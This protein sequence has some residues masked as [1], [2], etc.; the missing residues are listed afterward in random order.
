MP[1][2]IRVDSI[3]NFQHSVAEGDDLIVNDLVPDPG[4]LSDAEIDALERTALAEP[5]IVGGLLSK[6]AHVSSV[7]VRLEMPGDSRETTAVNKEVMDYARALRDDFEARYPNL[8]IHLMGQVVVNHAFNEIAEADAATLVPVM[9]VA[10][11]A[12]VGLFLRSLWS[13]VAMSAIIV[14]S[15]VATVGVLG[16]LGYQVNQINVSA[17]VIILTL[18]ISDCVHLL[19]H[20]LNDL[21]RGLGKAEA[22][23]HTI[24]IN[25]APVFLT[26]LTT[27]IGFFSLNTSDSPPFR[28]LGTVVGLGVFG[29]MLFTLTMLPALM[30]WLPSDFDPR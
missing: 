17:P 30:L 1:R 18:A 10:V 13:V 23:Q 7:N 5:A 21:R 22:M 26:T 8:D 20:Y 11:M 29:A 3:T 4:T 2:S 15:I 12:L 16:W 25:L 19:V 28:E 27:A 6:R 9:F 24:E 14:A